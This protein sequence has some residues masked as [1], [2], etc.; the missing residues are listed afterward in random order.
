M[1]QPRLL[2]SEAFQYFLKPDQIYHIFLIKFEEKVERTEI[3]VALV[4]LPKPHGLVSVDPVC[5][6]LNAEHL[7]EL[8]KAALDAELFLFFEKIP[9]STLCLEVDIE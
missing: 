4:F 9:G 3:P 7:L 2:L 6:A 8:F 5:F 1:A